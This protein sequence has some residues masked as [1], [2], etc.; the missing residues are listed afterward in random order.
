MKTREELEKAVE[1]ARAAWDAAVDAAASWRNAY[2]AWRDAKAA[3]EDYEEDED[4]DVVT[5]TLQKHI[6]IL[7]KMTNSNIEQGMFNVMDQI[8][9]KQINQMDAAIKM[10]KEKNT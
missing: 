6:E 7:L 4:Y 2:V 8:R 1:D 9:L 3:L 10:W 5:D